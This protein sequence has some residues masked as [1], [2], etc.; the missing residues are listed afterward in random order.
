[1]IVVALL[2]RYLSPSACPSL[3]RTYRRVRAFVV[4]VLSLLGGHSK[5]TT[6]EKVLF[7]K[8]ASHLFVLVVCCA[9]L[10]ALVLVTYT[11]TI[12]DARNPFRLTEGHVWGRRFSDVGWTGLIRAFSSRCSCFSSPWECM[13]S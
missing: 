2:L 7:V 11:F 13:R 4:F 12:Q 9:M 8:Q 10:V 5:I 6:R 1:V 3:L